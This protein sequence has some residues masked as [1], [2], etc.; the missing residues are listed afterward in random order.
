M[1]RLT[2]EDLIQEMLKEYPDLGYD[3]VKDFTENLV[4]AME[5]KELG[6]VEEYKAYED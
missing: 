3:F 2:K 5:E 4:K 6:D 1:N